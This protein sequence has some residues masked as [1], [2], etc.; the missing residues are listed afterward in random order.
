MEW[1]TLKKIYRFTPMSDIFQVIGYPKFQ[2]GTRPAY[3]MG[4]GFVIG[5][6]PT[7]FK[8]EKNDIIDFGE[9]GEYALCAY[10]FRDRNELELDFRFKEDEIFNFE[11]DII[12]NCCFEIEENILI[13]S[14]IDQ[15]ETNLCSKANY[16]KGETRDFNGANFVFQNQFI[17]CDKYTFYFYGKGK[18][19]KLSAF[20]F[21][22]N[23]E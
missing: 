8:M 15:V 13:N 1:N 12:G 18:K 2:L 23:V 20:K 11:G 9:K 14:T 21:L 10:Y 22:F 19:A 17:I 5:F 6:T 16:S 4:E 3:Y 7:K